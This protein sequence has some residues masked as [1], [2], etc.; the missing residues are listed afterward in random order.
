MQVGEKGVKYGLQLRVAPGAKPAAAARAAPAR[1]PSVFGDEDSDDE[2]A[3]GVEAQIARQAA[4]KQSDK[5]VGWQ[6]GRRQRGHVARRA[7]CSRLPALRCLWRTPAARQPCALHRA[8][9][10]GAARG[11]A[12]RGRC[13]L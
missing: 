3:D 13:H 1:K 10:G 5:K 12:S 4:R 7:H 9:G 6:A 11:G 8:A 2:R